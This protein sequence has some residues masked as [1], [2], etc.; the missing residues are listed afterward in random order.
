[1]EQKGFTEEEDGVHWA[2]PV[3]ASKENERKENTMRSIAMRTSDRDSTSS[4][5]ERDDSP[6]RESLH[7]DVL[8]DDHET[9]PQDT[10]E[11]EASA[12]DLY[13]DQDDSTYKSRSTPVDHLGTIRRSFRF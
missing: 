10:T 13:D 3:N 7:G 5:S 6:E 12:K 11:R 2:A 9:S 4:C 8:I 1:M